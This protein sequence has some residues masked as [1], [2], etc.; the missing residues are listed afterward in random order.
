VT[1][2]DVADVDQDLVLALLVPDL[3][4][5]VARIRDDDP[6]GALR[7]RNA[8]PMTVAVR[9]VR[10]RAR[11]PVAGQVL[12]DRVQAVPGSELGEDPFDD[13]RGGLVT[14]E[15]VQ[16]LAVGSLGRIRMRARVDQPVAGSM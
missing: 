16:A 8:A 11:D 12:G 2:R 3:P 15:G 1:E 7:P 10:G 5:G 9:V 6:D 13:G 4:A 14:G